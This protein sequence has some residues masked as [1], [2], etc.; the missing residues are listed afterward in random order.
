MA[1]LGAYSLFAPNVDPFGLSATCNALM[2]QHMLSHLSKPE[3]LVDASH[4]T[5]TRE[6]RETWTSAPESKKLELD[7]KPIM[8]NDSS[9][10]GYSGRAYIGSTD[11][12]VRTQT[13]RDVV[14]IVLML[15]LADDEI[16]SVPFRIS[17][18]LCTLDIGLGGVRSAIVRR[19]K[20]PLDRLFARVPICARSGRVTEVEAAI[21][22]DGDASV[23][24]FRLLLTRCAIYESAMDIPTITL[25]YTYLLTP[26]PLSTSISPSLSPS[27]SFRL[28]VPTPVVTTSRDKIIRFKPTSTPPMVP[29]IATVA[30]PTITTTTATTVQYSEISSAH[31]NDSNACG[32]HAPSP[33]PPRCFT[34][35]RERIVSSDSVRHLD[36]S[37][38][39][40][41]YLQHPLSTTPTF[42]F[43]ERSNSLVPQVAPFRATYRHVGRWDEQS[44]YV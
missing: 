29:P 35:P 34:T 25:Y 19:C 18:D 16:P 10:A 33:P 9:F 2:R 12:E 24:R 5:A 22:D 31:V 14:N 39:T 7:D 3:S 13:E 8:T 37:V 36:H 20:Y 42:T 23:T 26:P 27:T 44:R 21:G 1:P 40:K 4:V 28:A 15:A 43:L 38:S 11:V 6:I 17:L 32:K 30:I 41:P